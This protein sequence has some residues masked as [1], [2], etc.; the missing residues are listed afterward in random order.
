M[1][2]PNSECV[3][4]G[5]P[6][7]R[8]PLELKRTRHF[9]CMEHRVEAQRRDGLTPAQQIALELGR[10]KGTNHLNGIPKSVKSKRKRS[11]AMKLWCRDNPELVVN[12]GKRIRG[13]NHY[14]W[15]GGSSG[16][17]ISIRQMN[18][19][20]KWIDAVKARDSKCVLCQST[21]QLESHHIVP[22]VELIK[23]LDIQ[24]RDDARRNA[25]E[26]W[27]IDNGI[28]LCILCHYK[29]HGRIHASKRGS[30]P[31]DAT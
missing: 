8:R 31:N 18:E 14:R 16:L 26:L 21:Y 5:K 24:S 28:T 23:Q 29:R 25:T 13:E 15:K 3:I 12:R 9:A 20:R 6:F 30:I 27:N 17:N 2:T 22:L 1:R 11:K 7:Y 10:E 19:N 4:C